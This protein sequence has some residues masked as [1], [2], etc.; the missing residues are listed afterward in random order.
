M[1]PAPLLFRLVFLLASL[2]LAGCPQGAEAFF[3]G[4][5]SGM[6]MVHNHII[7][8]PPETIL[9]LLRV[10]GRFPDARPEHIEL[11]QES[12]IAWWAHADKQAQMLTYAPRLTPTEARALKIWLHHP[13][14]DRGPG[15]TATMNA[16]GATLTPLLPQNETRMNRLDSTPR[17]PQ[18]VHFD[19]RVPP[20]RA[21][22]AGMKPT[23]ATLAVA[24]VCLLTPPA[25]ALPPE[26]PRPGSGARTTTPPANAGDSCKATLN[27]LR[28]GSVLL[29]PHYRQQGA[30]RSPQKTPGEPNRLEA[31]LGGKVSGTYTLKLEG[32]CETEIVEAIFTS[33][34]Y[35]PRTLSLT[36]G[37]EQVYEP[38]LGDFASGGQKALNERLAAHLPRCIERTG[39]ESAVPKGSLGRLQ[40]VVRQMKRGRAGPGSLPKVIARFEFPLDI[41]CR[42]FDAA[43]IRTAN[44]SPDTLQTA[45]GLCTTRPGDHVPN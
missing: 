4:R 2:G 34:L 26:A 15:K 41:E 35:Q 32:A 37:K 30:A 43:A 9:D 13:A 5:P 33:G 28:P 1:L 6:S 8:G 29:I 21:K 20:H 36:P 10:P 23:P 24:L 31:G 22:G 11:W 18:N 42:G 14:R 38:L 44:C 7:G 12:V 45:A 19:H 17:P 40:I 16:A 27:L 39:E 3:S 25:L